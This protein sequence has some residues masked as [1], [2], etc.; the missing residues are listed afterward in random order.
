MN[1]KLL[2]IL[3]I[4]LTGCF[5]ESDDVNV[6]RDD[7]ED[8]RNFAEALD[9]ILPVFSVS[10]ARPV[11]RGDTPASLQNLNIK[12]IP[13]YREGLQFDCILQL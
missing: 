13:I 4:L 5:K 8:A 12:W 10:G 6:L 2:I 7:Q 9:N 1:I 11:S 3:S